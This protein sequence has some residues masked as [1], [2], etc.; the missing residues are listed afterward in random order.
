M[1]QEIDGLQA[2]YLQLASCLHF[3]RQEVGGLL[4]RYLQSVSCLHTETEL[5]TE[6]R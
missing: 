2:R 5:T 6:T 3:L 4:V 1:R